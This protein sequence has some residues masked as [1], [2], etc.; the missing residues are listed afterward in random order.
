MSAVASRVRVSGPGLHGGK[1][2][3]I[4]LVAS[5]T[6]SG[7]TLVM[8]EQRGVLPDCPVTSAFRSTS[9]AVSHATLRTVEH[10]CAALMGLGID[11]GLDIHV[12]GDEIPLLD[13]GASAWVSA[14][15]DALPARSSAS[16]SG[17]PARFRI[18]HA[19]TLQDDDARYT[20]TPSSGIHL[21]VKVELGDR[22]YDRSA[23]WDGSRTAFVQ[24]VAPARTFAREEDVMELASRGVASWVPRESVV[25]L[26]KERPA[27]FHGRPFH[28]DE[29]ARHKLLDLMGDVYVRCGLL[30]GTL[31]AEKPGHQR[32]HRVLDRALADGVIV[33]T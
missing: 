14:L 23:T 3:S 4:T 31:A 7:V 2:S 25:V 22:R 28:D 30:Q 13:G 32:T 11:S 24:D 19:A 33:R 10:L 21:S 20:F 1:T 16:P 18:A 29:P 5:D 8:G 15:E 12:E 6:A 26:C 9:I 17:H 27:L